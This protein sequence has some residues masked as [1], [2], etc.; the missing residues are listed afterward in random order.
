MLRTT[1]ERRDA[2]SGVDGRSTLPITVGH[3]RELLA[4][5]GA[6]GLQTP[7]GGSLTFALTDADGRLLAP[8]SRNS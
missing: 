6:W 7:E 2:A 4:R 1:A 8:P 5:L 3:L